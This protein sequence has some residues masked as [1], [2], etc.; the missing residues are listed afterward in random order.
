MKLDTA[1]FLHA[2]VQKKH[3][4]I[5]VIA[6]LF[7]AATLMLAGWASADPPERVARLGYISGAVSF[8]PAGEDDWVEAGINR[9]LITG[10]RLWVDDGARAELQI[11]SAVF[12]MGG[13][14]SVT[15]LN[16]DDRVA[17]LQL[18]QGTLNVRVRRLGPRDVVEVDTPNLAYSIRRPGGYRIDVDPAGDATTV[19]TRDGQAEVYGE[20]AAH[21][22]NA[23]QTYRYFGT[24][25]RDYDYLEP[26]RDD[27]F[28][29]WS[30][31]RDRRAENS[32]SARYVSRD[33]IGY[34]DLDEHGSWRS[35]EGYGNVWVPNRVPVGWAPYHDGHWAWVEPWGWTWVD[36]APWGFAVSHYGRWADLGGTWGW[37]PGPVLA[38]PVYAPALV[39]FIGGSN[40]RLSISI[41]NAGSVGWFPLGPRDVYRPSYPVSRTYF[42]NVNTSN[43]T[44]N[45]TTI[46]NVYNNTRVTNVTYVNQRVPGAV[47]AVPATAF[48]Q[49]HPVAKAAIPVSKEAI[50]KAPVTPVAS[51]APVQTSVRGAAPPGRKP[52]A[53][54]QARPV[55]ARAP[56]PPAPVPFAAKQSALAAN[57]GK[58]LDAAAL[59]AVKPAAPAPA[60][61]VKVV[62]PGQPAVAPPKQQAAA[63]NRPRSSEARKGQQRPEAQEGPSPEAKTAPQ[64]PE[65]QKGPP[66]EAKKAPQPP[67]AQKGPQAAEEEQGRPPE[68]RKGPQRPEAQEGPPPEA[69][70]GPQRPEE[71]KG[72]PPEAQKAPQ[73]PVS[74]PQ[75][76]VR[77]PR[78]P[79]SPK[80][81]TPEAQ[82]GPPSEA[83]KAPQPPE[84]Q[85]GP[86]PRVSVPRPPET[87]KGRPPEAQK[88][89]QPPGRAPQPAASVPRPPETPKGPTAEAQRAPK[90]DAARR[91]ERRGEKRD[92]EEQ[93]DRKQ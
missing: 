4:R 72:R 69:K 39:A 41:G 28:D 15:L 61:A 46:T 34:E 32:V 42:N 18:A 79:E 87:P 66:P 36:D 38:P 76:A 50:A 89:Q 37:V 80:G 60:P 35:A 55:V 11:G 16:L 54:A 12:Y 44:V 26:A 82:R 85:R 83:Q 19:A 74:T 47:I 92:E 45:N 8:S 17:Q 3:S 93:K 78:P 64:P 5:R 29:R 77:V 58:P 62:S 59:A 24:S 81:P 10:D 52:P 70:K 65:A 67:E 9:P 68:A 6:L 91:A 86:P 30:Y 40:F 57:P 20:G 13:G 25:L 21:L 49:S 88:A 33:V 1:R 23:G 22:V 90:P 84:A 27:E 14:T 31:D 43:T 56:P 71:Q 51:V 2:T 48:A 7:G 73:P 53:E 75:R 63:P